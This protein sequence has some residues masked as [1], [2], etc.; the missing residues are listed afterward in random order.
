[1]S[2][3]VA[4]ALRFPA[5]SAGLD[6]AARSLGAILDARRVSPALRYDVEVVFEELAGNIV[7]H[8]KPVGEI[9]VGL[10][11]DG[12]IVLTFEDDGAAF[13]PRQQL[14]PPEL[15]S[16]E[17]A[18]VGGLGLVLVRKLCSRIEYERTAAGRN[19]LTVSVPPR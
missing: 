9:D 7:R 13:D 11:F 4:N 8:A 2:S 3:D 14:S 6:E 10:A 16:L 1:M 12:G 5:T 17:E 19:R 15:E 18:R